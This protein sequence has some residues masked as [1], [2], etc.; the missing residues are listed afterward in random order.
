MNEP[1]SAA[2]DQPAALPSSSSCGEQTPARPNRVLGRPLTAKQQTIWD[3]KRSIAEGGQGKKLTEIAAVMGISVPVVSKTLHAVYRKLGFERTPGK[4]PSRTA[5]EY[6]NPEK[7]AAIIDAITEPE[8]IIKLKQAYKEC[9]LPEG[10]SAA[11]V[12]RLKN[13]YF[14][15]ITQTRNLKASEIAQLFSEKIDLAARY[16]DDKTAGDASFRDL[17]LAATAMAEKRQL[18]RGEPTQII[19]DHERA[20]LHELVPLLIQEARRRGLT[21][22]GEI[23]E[24]VVGPA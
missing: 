23:T 15:G 7:A 2:Q 8:A 1:T 12:R 9:G 3:L 22:E 5:T 17:A 20:K 4:A 11:L 14:G 16:M 6:N 24:K 13:K 19:S 10:V 21:V 18:M